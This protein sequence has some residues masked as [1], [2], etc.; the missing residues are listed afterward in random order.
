MNTEKL[1][2][3]LKAFGEKHELEDNELLAMTLI[4]CAAILHENGVSLCAAENTMRQAA[5][6]T[7]SSLEEIQ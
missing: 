1:S 5:R 4:V 6:Y 3:H 2:K 7:Y